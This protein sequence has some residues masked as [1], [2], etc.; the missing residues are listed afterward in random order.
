MKNT[1]KE[2]LERIVIK[3][4]II[5]D[6][7]LLQYECNRDNKIVTLGVRYIKNNTIQE[8]I[9]TTMTL[10]EYINEL[11]NIVKININNSAIAI[12]KKE[13]Y[14]NVFN[15]YIL[16]DCYDLNKHTFASSEFLDIEYNEKFPNNKVD[17]YLVVKK[18]Y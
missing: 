10:D 11:D 8:N 6:N 2:D 13:T 3:E 12:F 14:R 17:K 9:L 15:E 7:S 1:I 4:E 16:H 5:N 18:K